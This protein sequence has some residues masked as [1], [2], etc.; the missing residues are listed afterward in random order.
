MTH[1]RS[2]RMLTVDQLRAGVADESI[3]T[4]VVAFTDMQGRLQG[5]YLHAAY[6]VEH[7]LGHGVEGCNYLLAVDTEM[8]TVDGYAISSWEAGYG[9]ME[10]TL[11]LDTIR[12]VPWLERTVMIQC[13]LALTDGSPV[14]MSPRSMLAAQVE[15]A[16][17]HGWSA[18]AGTE[19][20]FVVYRDSF[21]EAWTKG[22]TG[23]T[24]A[25]QY[26]VD[27]SIVG[28]GRVEPLLRRI[29][30]DMWRA[31]MTVESAKGECNFGQHEIGFLFDDVVTTCDNHSVYKTGA[32][33]IAADL[34]QSLTFMAKP[35][36]REGNSCH[37]HLSLRGLDG[38]TVFWADG[39]RT[40]LYDH[41]IAGVLAT[42]REF[43]LFYAPNINSYKRFAQGSFAPTA[44]A[45]GQDNR[46][47]SVRT[48]GEGSS[49][50]MENRVPGGDCNPYLAV[51]AMMAGG[52]H[53]I[54]NELELEPMMTGNAYESDAPLVPH[55][56][57]EARDLFAASEVAREAFGQDVVDHY[58]NM[59][60]VE[61]T[62]FDAAVTDWELRRGFERL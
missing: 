13:D 52:L 53:G 62:A 2:E 6:F 33:M 37:I 48:V 58:V 10:F 44:V 24:P 45:W 1:P 42:M 29:R 49:A 59:A 34:G 25:N 15:R 20:E 19:L 28:S 36:E 7:A 54:E 61:I 30:A 21:E 38:S 3:E 39:E 27:Y 5:K 23:L 32:K 51:A 11:D 40:P 16:A 35:N 50:R 56:L 4:V 57:R 26:N 17:G 47:C 8:N 14:P 43:T 9:D 41:F 12:W 18:V 55:T 22:Y 46:T 60:D 31:G